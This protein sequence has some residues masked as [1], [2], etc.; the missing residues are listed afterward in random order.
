MTRLQAA[1]LAAELLAAGA[2]VALARRRPHHGPAAVVL[3]LLFLANV[4]RAPIAA[5]LLP[6]QAEPWEGTQRLL[7]Y[8]DG[9]LVLVAVAVIPGLAFSVFLESRRQKIVGVGSVAGAWAL[10][11]GWLAALYPSPSVRGAALARFYLAVDLVA[12]FFASA[13]LVWW[14]RLRRSPDSAHFVAIT[15]I[16][17]DIAILI[18]PY[19]PWR[20]GYFNGRAETPQVMTIAIF[21]VLAIVQGVLWKFSQV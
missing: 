12:L 15:F 1:A 8:L 4:V 14:A 19:S 2:A 6:P 17:L 18:T 13:A 16:V 10:A 11:S 9:A 7:V 20:V 3:T 21:S 5:A